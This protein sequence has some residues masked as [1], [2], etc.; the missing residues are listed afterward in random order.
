MFFGSFSFVDAPETSQQEKSSADFVATF[1][2]HI[3]RRGYR[4]RKQIC[5][6][7]GRMP[8]A[9][10]HCEKRDGQWQ[11]TTAKQGR[12]FCWLESISSWDMW[13]KLEILEV[14]FVFKFDIFCV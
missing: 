5:S 10:S 7:S 9:E 11:D 3:F 2:I 8:A 12:R 1:P 4:W 6:T 13:K 14:F